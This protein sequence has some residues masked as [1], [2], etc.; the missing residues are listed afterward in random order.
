MSN[1]LA[2]K[3]H[4]TCDQRFADEVNSSWHVDPK[5]AARVVHKRKPVVGAHGGV[6]KR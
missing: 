5:V 1:A 4:H 3:V 2:Q 6:S